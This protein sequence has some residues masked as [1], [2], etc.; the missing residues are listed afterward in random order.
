[1]KYVTYFFL[2]NLFLLKISAQG[3]TF[4]PQNFWQVDTVI[5][6]PGLN[7]TYR[8]PPTHRPRWQSLHLFRNA[9]LLQAETDYRLAEKPKR[10]IF[11]NA[12]AAGD[13]LRIRYKRRPFALKPLFT[14]F[15]V[16]T[17]SKS[18]S[19][20]IALTKK[21]LRLKAVKFEN[22]FAGLNR[23]LQTSGSIMR[24][25]R[26]GSNRDFSLN[27]GLN[28]S[29]SGK[30]TDNLEVVAALTD[31]AT[32]IQPEG[33][34]KTLQEVDKVFVAFKSPYV[35][36]TVG[37]FNLEYKNS[38]FADL[39][40]KLQGISIQGAYKG[41]GLGATIAATR[42]YF[43]HVSF[44]GQEGRQG[45]YQ[46]TGAN[47]Q[48]DI[49]VLAG[50]EQVWLDGKKM[51]RGENNDYVIEYG[52]G[53]IRFTNHRLITGES[54]IEVDFE[55]FP[56]IQ[57]YNRN[58]YSVT[59]GHTFS[60]DRLKLNFRLYRENDDPSQSLEQGQELSATEKKI[61]QQAGDDPLKAFENGVTFQ[62]DS[63]G[64][65][66]RRDTVLNGQTYT[67]YRYIGKKKGDYSLRF[68]EV[69]Q[70]K[71]DYIRDRLGV[72]SWK[73]P[74]LGRFAPLHLLP[75]PSLQELADMRLRW[76]ASDYAGVQAEYA[77]SRLDKNTLSNLDDQDN[78][79][80]AVNLNAALTDFPLK[81]KNKNLGLLSAQLS[82]RY[83]EELFRAPGR[84][85]K[86]DYRRYWNVLPGAQND[87]A[88]QRYQ[89][90]INYRPR[91][92]FTL[93]ANA[94]QLHKTA[95]NSK[96]YQGSAAYENTK[97]KAGIAYEL[98]S[99]QLNRT[100]TN[101][102]W[103]RYSAMLERTLWK[104]RPGFYYKGEWRKNITEGRLSGF[105]FEK[106]G[107]KLALAN[108]RHL[109][110]FVQY[111]KRFDSVYDFDLTGKL[112]PQAVGST[113]R[114]S[115][116]LANYPHTSA[117]LQLV[118]RQKTY[119]SEFKKIKI[120]TLKLNYVDASVQDTVWQDRTTNLAQL[121]V[122]HSRWKK[123]VKFSLQYRL[124]SERVALKEKVYL[125]V[126]SG[127]GNLRYDEDLQEYVPDADGK[128][129]LFILPSGKFEPV[130]N[131]QTAL[132]FNLDPRRY[133][134]KVR[135]GY[136]KWLSAISSESYFRVDEE[137]GERDVRSIYLLNLSKFQGTHTLHG[138]LQFNQ[139]FYILRRNRRLSFRV[140]YR[141]RKSRSNQF[142]NP[143]E[144]EDR[145][146]QEGGLR[147]DWRVA[148]GL[149]SRSQFKLKTI[150]RQSTANSLRNRRITGFYLDQNFSYQPFVRWEFGLESE[151]GNEK[152]DQ[153]AYPL[154]LWY[155][156]V[157][158]RL[159]YSIA[160]KGRASAEYRYQKVQPLSNP[161]NYA[162]PYE[163]ARGRKQGVSQDWRLRLE[164]T[165]TKNIVFNIF[166]SGRDEAGFEKVIH[167]GQAEIRA[168]F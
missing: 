141:F 95:L 119:S 165:V 28:L 105:R 19:G 92:N 86:A 85:Q 89:L 69:G 114:L 90:S 145:K 106:L 123:A 164:Y 96:R 100:Q 77:L 115:L 144:N 29:L 64:S 51:T 84:I 129:L 47:G 38:R 88:E 8:F 11:F 82:G 22:P 65:Y 162:I 4:I 5:V 1:M 138:A 81:I 155:G 159:S 122:T 53:Q 148:G 18:D 151:Y 156:T 21:T 42:G 107:A 101:N 41:Q 39:A 160:G 134:R 124:S 26:I 104:F 46:L 37:D 54:R 27:S 168:F 35:W 57:K 136:K 68:S 103:R 98:I 73:G 56:A 102:T 110:G 30:L 167:S 43:N 126:G 152:N 127:R 75:L 94:G 131:L 118:H 78:T 16:D 113:A 99:S 71:G 150:R 116:N 153:P 117:S 31:E 161:L 166:Y 125:D 24:G 112:L 62:G 23:T 121:N 61:L 143:K 87:P 49:V 132:R 133:W 120:D 6:N 44:L 146:T 139:D 7:Y 45:P 15:R 12:F 59:S 149:R 135:G 32:P 137:T 163:M 72:Y 128:Y 147:A 13:T 60:K 80:S 3:Q 93:L 34:T 91:K 83:V 9:H 79:G 55:Y 50:T 10:I 140:R 130:T 63:A 109:Q 25:V 36:G 76:K 52:N 97:T 67:Y 70:G 14:L 58:V 48:R 40:R 20:N 154:K 108:W 142:L 158:G 74:N 111:S 66:V 33:N 2:V 157:K 17:L